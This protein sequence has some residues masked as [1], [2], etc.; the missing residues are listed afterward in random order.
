MKEDGGLWRR[1]TSCSVRDGLHEHLINNNDVS[2]HQYG[3]PTGSPQI[4]Y[5]VEMPKLC[6]RSRGMVENN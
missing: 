2:D 1:A 5:A 6:D 4:M 3:F